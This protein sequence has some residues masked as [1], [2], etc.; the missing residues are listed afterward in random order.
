MMLRIVTEK[1]F[2]VEFYKLV[3]WLNGDHCVCNMFML[4]RFLIESRY[5]QPWSVLNGVKQIM[6]MMIL[7]LD[8]IKLFFMDIAY[9]YVLFM[10]IWHRYYV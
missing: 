8:Y 9:V 3:L 2:H 1:R 5:G 10:P 6:V 4:F 7:M